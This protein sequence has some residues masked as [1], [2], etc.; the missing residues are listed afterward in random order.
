MAD[1]EG[2]AADAVR[3]HCPDA[4]GDDLLLALGD[5]SLTPAI[6]A[7]LGLGA[8]EQPPVPR[9]KVSMRPIF[10]SG[11]HGCPGRTPTWGQAELAAPEPE[12]HPLLGWMRRIDAFRKAHARSKQ[13]KIYVAPITRALCGPFSAWPM[14][15]ISAPTTPNYRRC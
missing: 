14:I 10:I 13:G 8:T 7:V 2:A 15:S 3:R 11:L 12:Q 4:L 6:K 5:V 9:M 1:V